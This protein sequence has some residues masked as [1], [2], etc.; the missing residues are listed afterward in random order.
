MQGITICFQVGRQK[1]HFPFQIGVPDFKT[2]PICPGSSHA[3]FPRAW[4]E[5]LL[6][7]QRHLFVPGEPGRVSETLG[8]GLESLERREA[9]FWATLQKSRSGDC[10]RFAKGAWNSWDFP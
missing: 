7:L 3:L 10:S 2:H 6:D 4:A 9:P 8:S 5:P 1:E